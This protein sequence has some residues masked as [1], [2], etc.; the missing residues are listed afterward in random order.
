MKAAINTSGRRKRSIA[1]ATLTEGKG[2]VRIN[3]K[4]LDHY[5]PTLSRL[6]IMEP[7]MIAS[8]ISKKID[9]EVQVNGGG[10]QSQ[11]E[12]I[13]LAI[14]R[15]MVQYSKDKTL[16]QRFLDYDKHLLIADVRFAEASKP[17]DS[18][19]RA[20]RQKSYR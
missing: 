15:A 20:S 16:K 14:A 3:S 12:A 6:K 18:K 9:I 1:R 19:P 5:Q 8:D 17:N 13:R 11:T 4:L 10:Y 2:I 7:L